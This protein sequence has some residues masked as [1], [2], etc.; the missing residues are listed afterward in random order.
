[1][2]TGLDDSEARI[3]ADEAWAARARARLQDCRRAERLVLKVVAAAFGI[4]AVP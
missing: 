1:M 2:S 3:R 4:L